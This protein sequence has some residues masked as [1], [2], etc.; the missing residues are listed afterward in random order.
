MAT[1]KEDPD[2]WKAG[3]LKKRDFQHSHDGPEEMPHRSNKRGKAKWCRRKVGREHD[4]SGKVE[5][6]YG[7]TMKR[8]YTVCSA[9]GKYEN[10]MGKTYRLES[11]TIWTPSGP[12]TEKHWVLWSGWW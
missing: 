6:Q 11:F 2:S 10:W 5:K 1:Q 3:G 8:V 7:P 9:C 12:M 4:F